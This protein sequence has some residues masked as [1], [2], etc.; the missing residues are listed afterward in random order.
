MT[1]IRLAAK[2]ENLEKFLKFISVLA[3]QNDLSP[4][5]AMKIRL[6]IEEAL[7][8]ILNYAYPGCNGD[9]E[10]RFRKENDTKL[11]LEIFD[12][13]IPFDPLSL[14]KPDLTANISDRKVGGLGVFFMREMAEDVH[15][16]REGDS[17]ILTMIFCR[18]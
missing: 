13:G 18:H 7:V 5:T 15:Y 12:N 3:E 16:R 6:S 1:R 10:I 8:N 4:D 9:V 11:V 17:N 2:Q 14:P